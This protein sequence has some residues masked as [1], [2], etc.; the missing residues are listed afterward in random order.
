MIL[1]NNQLCLQ[2]VVATNTNSHFSS[3]IRHKNQ[4]W[5]AHD[6]LSVEWTHYKLGKDEKRLKKYNIAMFVYEVCPVIDILVDNEHKKWIDDRIIGTVT[7]EQDS[8]EQARIGK[9]YTES[10]QRGKQVTVEVD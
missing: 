4:V 9:V 8:D 2:G 5:T 7:H 6:G 10:R 1:G 3:L